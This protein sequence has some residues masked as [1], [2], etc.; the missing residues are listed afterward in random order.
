MSEILL[1]HTVI[2]ATRRWVKTVVVALNLCPFAKRELQRDSVRFSVSAAVTEEQ[3]LMDLQTEL[4]LLADDKKVETSLLIHPEILQDFDDYNQ[5][6]NYSDELLVAMEL[7]GVF[8]IASFHPD[9]QFAGAEQDAAENF[10]NR[11]P[12]PMLHLIRESSVEKAVA[13]Y[14]GSDQIP[15]RNIELLQGLGLAKMQALLQSCLVDEER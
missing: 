4:E 1:P 5:F 7:N 9:Y 3:L 15:Q 6:L 13:S 2:G 12:Y 10:S 11:S 8:Q 14:P